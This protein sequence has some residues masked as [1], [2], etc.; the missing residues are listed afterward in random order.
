MSTSLDIVRTNKNLV[1][2]KCQHLPS[3]LGPS[4]ALFECT[5]SPSC[6]T[7]IHFMSHVVFLEAS[8]RDEL[9]FKLIPDVSP[10]I[11]FSSFNLYSHPQFSPFRITRSLWLTVKTSYCTWTDILLHR[12]PLWILD[13]TKTYQI[14]SRACLISSLSATLIILVPMTLQVEPSTILT[15]HFSFA[16]KE[17]NSSFLE[18]T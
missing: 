14:T 4:L 17:L 7:L 16:T 18:H 11:E 12:V 10:R 1:F 3:W 8:P 13:C 5:L 2:F 9:S 6:N 15:I